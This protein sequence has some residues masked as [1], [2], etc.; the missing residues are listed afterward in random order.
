LRKIVVL[1]DPKVNIRTLLKDHLGLNCFHRAYKNNVGLDAYA[2]KQYEFKGAS[3]KLVF[4]ELA[5]TE[6]FS[7]QF[8]RF[9]QGAKAFV[10]VFD[11]T[12][13]DILL[14]LEQWFFEAIKKKNPKNN[15]LVRITLIFLLCPN[16]FLTNYKS[17]VWF[18]L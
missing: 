15:K 16:I 2:D 18:L 5:T 11:Y 10:I 6:K 4:Y 1:G 13:P 12:L 7:S 14:Q 9:V 8:S 3:F 17:T